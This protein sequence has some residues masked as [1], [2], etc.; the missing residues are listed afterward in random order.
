MRKLIRPKVTVIMNVHNGEEFI[1]EAIASVINQTYKNWE[2][3]IWDNFS[4]DK[5]FELIRRFKDKR[6]TYFKSNT[7]DKLYTARN[8]AM[9]ISNGD[10]ITFLDSDDIWLPNKLEE[11]TNIMKDN[12]IDYCYSNFFQINK[13]SKK[14]FPPKAYYSYLPSGNI[15]NNLLQKYTVGILTLCLRK[16]SLIKFGMSFDPRYSII[17][18]MVFVLELS[19]FGKSYATQNCLAC[20]R[21]HEGNLSKRRVLMQVREMRK[22]FYDLK[23][24]GKWNKKCYKSLVNLTK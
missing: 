24:N 19:E 15:Y 9:N 3:L 21:I 13:K 14:I 18:D 23:K 8:K 5:T 11:Q 2:L 7:F 10:L 16:E 6:I 20:Y 22:W 4:T 1:S 17:G 12:K